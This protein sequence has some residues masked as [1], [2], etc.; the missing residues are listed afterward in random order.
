MESR[1]IAVIHLVWLPYGIEIFKNFIASYSL[2]S[3]GIDHQLI[4]L[5]NGVD[6]IISI[7]SYSNYA[8]EKKIEF[9]ILILEKGLDIEAYFFA[10]KNLSADLLFFINTNSALLS[11]N[12]LKKMYD[13]IVKEN[14]G[15]VSATGTL[16]SHSSSPFM[17][18]P[19][20]YQF[21]KKLKYNYRKYKLFIK[22]AIYWKVLFEGFP[23]PHL[24]TNAFM[25]WKNIFL[26]IKYKPITSKMRAYEFESGRNSI[27][28][29]ILH[30]KK[31]VLVVDKFGIGYEIKNWYGSKTFWENDQENLMISDNQ[32]TK[33]I[34]AD[35][36]EKKLYTYLAWGKK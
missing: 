14:V 19:F 13:N 32:T 36:T 21:S 20:R 17:S 15:M 26:E 31:K 10:A 18:M 8:N 5:F 33:Y 29:Q 24:R 4:F 25:I 34:N 27:T 30:K 3:A 22:S 2:Y 12:W 9:E 7:K 11:E 1:K 28:N 16:Q 6:D 23:N 35:E